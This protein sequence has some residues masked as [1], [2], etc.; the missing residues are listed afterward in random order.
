MFAW[1]YVFHCHPH[2]TIYITFAEVS[3]KFKF[4]NY[5]FLDF[6]IPF[7]HHF[8][9]QCWK[10]FFYCENSSKYFSFFL[11]IWIVIKFKSIK[12]FVVFYTKSILAIWWLFNYFIHPFPFFFFLLNLLNIRISIFSERICV[13]VLSSNSILGFLSLSNF[14][15]E[16]L[17]SFFQFYSNI[18][19]YF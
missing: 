19:V 10:F 15:F 9:H 13:S 16:S 14:Y 4:L 1:I 8:V 7:F 18:Y 5:F 12:I 17:F 6:K 2:S 11:V 3:P